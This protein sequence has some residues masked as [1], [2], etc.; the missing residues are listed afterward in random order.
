M[1]AMAM[2]MSS[3]AIN[4]HHDPWLLNR[5]GFL[6]VMHCETIVRTEWDIVSCQQGGQSKAKAHKSTTPMHVSM[7]KLVALDF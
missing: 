7:Y 6:L 1:I 4:G 5:A 3:I 2:G